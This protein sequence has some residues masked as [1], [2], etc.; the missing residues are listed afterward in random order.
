MLIIA[1]HLDKLYWIQD[2]MP[3]K[4]NFILVESYDA[5]LSKMYE[6]LNLIE[7]PV[8]KYMITLINLIEYLFDFLL[9]ELFVCAYIN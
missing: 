4:Q 8:S 2:K 3:P 5:F 9:E 1:V 6:K 7:N